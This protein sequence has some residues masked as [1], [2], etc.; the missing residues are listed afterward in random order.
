[1]EAAKVKWPDLR[2]A[3]LQMIPRNYL[4]DIGGHL[5]PSLRRYNAQV[6]QMEAQRNDMLSEVHETADKWRKMSGKNAAASAQFA[7]LLHESTLVGV[8]P[9]LAEFVPSMTD[10]VYQFLMNRAKAF[11]KSRNGEA[12]AVARGMERRR[13]IQAAYDRIPTQREAYAQ[14]RQQFL[15]MPAEYQ[16][17]FTEVRDSYQAMNAK[18]KE[19]IEKRIEDLIADKRVSAAHIVAMR[20]E[21]E[22]AELNGFYVPLQRFGKYRAA[23]KNEET[24]ELLA[25]SQFE[26]NAEMQQWMTEQRAPGVSV[27]GGYQFEYSRV[28]DGVSQGFVKDLM[29]KFGPQLNKNNKLQD[30]LYQLML[31]HMPDLS[32]R[33]HMIHRKGVAGYSADALRAF[34]HNQFHTA[35]QIAKISHTH[36]MQSHI[37]ALED[38]AKLID[39]TDDRVK[40]VQ[41]VNE[42]QQ[43]NEWILNPKGSEWANH[44]T[45]WGFL[46][47]LGVSPAAALVNITQTAM[48]GLPVIGARY[49]FKE[50]ATML[51]RV[52]KAFITGKG[53]VDN[54]LKDRELNAFREL[55]RSGIID[56]TMAHDLTGIADGGV[57]YRPRYHLV[58]KY[59]G[60]MFHHA[61]RFN[62]EVT[63]MAA[64]RLA[65]NKFR[66]K[67]GEGLAHNLAIAEAIE[68]TRLSHFD[69]AN[70]NRP[71]FMQGDVARV[72]LLFRQHSIN[73]TYRLI[74]DFQQSFWGN[75]EDKKIAQRQLAGMLG[76]TLLFA[77]AAGLP[78][79]SVVAGIFNLML[80]DEDEP[81]DFDKAV[82]ETL[83]D[84]IGE[85]AAS[86]IMSG[87]PGAALNVDLTNR[88]GMNNLWIRDPEADVE[89]E[90]A[91]QY[92]A[93]QALGPMY[94]I[95]AGWGKAATLAREGHTGRAWESA[96]PKFARD[97]FKAVRYGDEGVNTKRGDPILDDV[98]PWHLAL[99]FNGFT[100]LDLSDQYR[101]NNA[102]STAQRRLRDRRKLLLNRYALA[103][104][105][106]DG[107]AVAD[108][109]LEI[110]EFNLAQPTLNISSADRVK[111]LKQ[112]QRLSQQ[113]VNGVILDKKLASL[114]D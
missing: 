56:K 67:H 73:M 29:L 38:E 2:P 37:L 112:R 76:M 28:V 54:T 5:L 81:F 1:V 61:E 33:K 75:G 31:D 23:V 46:W 34:A 106:D 12:E 94:G 105:L 10:K 24:G 83:S 82:R 14:L 32:I 22:E 62:R 58:M 30:E 8:D 113:A 101:E 114:A 16:A 78:L 20:E 17:L 6:A 99:T 50:T 52:S 95:L 107:G 102:L 65:F 85:T 79:Y 108:V 18:R 43:R 44:L 90:A 47:Y 48:V 27:Q 49:G 39:D 93:E 11:I 25:Y 57:A 4:A 92:Y 66:G 68:L 100:P 15:A 19:A 110:D 103:R 26:S 21:F 111:S 59:A 45:G 69:Y 91:V 86:V 3:M 53:N 98:S 80:D 89:G 7:D 72:I 84:A 55:E 60:W 74:R 41:V 35:Y 70:S 51:G 87:T 104:R 40:A 77:G 63:A 97:W 71:R 96:V 109:L 64:Y 42:L 13:R 36:H 9:S 88:I